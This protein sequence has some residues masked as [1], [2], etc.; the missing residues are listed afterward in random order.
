MYSLR[1]KGENGSML[2]YVNGDVAGAIAAVFL[3]FVLYIAIR[4]MISF[5]REKDEELSR[6]RR[7]LELT[8]RHAKFK[9]K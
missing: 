3:L 9:K 2:A 5:Q 6:S 1:L 7:I 4:V 8:K